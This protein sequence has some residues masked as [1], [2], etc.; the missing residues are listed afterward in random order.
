MDAPPSQFEQIDL[1]RHQRATLPVLVVDAS[2]VLTLMHH[3][4]SLKIKVN[5]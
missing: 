2:E 4:G 3:C 1:R 5:Q